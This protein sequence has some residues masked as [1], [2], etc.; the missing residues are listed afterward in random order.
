[1]TGTLTLNAEGDDDAVWVFLIGSTL[2]TASA[3]DVVFIN[4]GPTPDNGLFW[5]VGSSAT[6]G[7]TSAFEGNILADQSITLNTGAT[8]DCGRALAQNGAVTMD[9]NTVST[10]CLGTGLETSGGLDASGTE[11]APTI[12]EPASI[13]LLGS[14]LVVLIGLTWR[15]NRINNRRIPVGIFLVPTRTS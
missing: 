1:L 8:I 9:T 6:L 10:G 12:P 15:R 3:S 2:T 4:L 11:S 14:G 13:T 5:D 7:T